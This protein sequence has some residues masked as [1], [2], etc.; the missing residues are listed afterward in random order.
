MHLFG[1][2]VILTIEPRLRVCDINYINEN[3]GSIDK[4]TFFPERCI[5]NLS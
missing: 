2:Y 5:L 1:K 4:A 3:E